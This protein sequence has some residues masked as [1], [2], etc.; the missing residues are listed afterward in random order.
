MVGAGVLF[1]GHIADFT[2]TL[3]SELHEKHVIAKLPPKVIK[4]PFCLPLESFSVNCRHILTTFSTWPR[5][6]SSPVFFLK[7]KTV[8]P[9]FRKISLKFKGE[10]GYSE[11][12]T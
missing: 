6:F 2:T 4:N 7:G 8:G 3:T 12:T 5:L 11:L 10:R 9:Q 1:E